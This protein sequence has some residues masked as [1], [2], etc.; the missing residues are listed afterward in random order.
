[1][2]MEYREKLNLLNNAPNQPFK[3]RTKD[4]V[5]ING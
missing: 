1:M 4:W 5:D 2:I 3:F